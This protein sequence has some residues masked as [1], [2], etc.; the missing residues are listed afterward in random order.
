VPSRE[1]LINQA[2]QAVTT[3][4][5][6]RFYIIAALVLGLLAYAILYIGQVLRVE[7]DQTTIDERLGELTQNS[8]RLDEPVID[9]IRA[10]QQRQTTIKQPDIGSN[11]FSLSD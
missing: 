7:P 11:P 4:N 9:E 1:E 5:K 3:I 8:I 6:F 10:R 2:K